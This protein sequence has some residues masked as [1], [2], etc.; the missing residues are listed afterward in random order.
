MDDHAQLVATCLFMPGIFRWAI[1]TRKVG[2]THLVFNGVR[3]G[4]ISRSVYARLHA[5]VTSCATPVNIQTQIHT[6]F[7]QLI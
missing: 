1:L 7:D 2:H 6:H 3:S 5:A 4:F